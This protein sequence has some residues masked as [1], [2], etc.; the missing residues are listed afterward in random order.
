M[1]VNHTPLT[2]APPILGLRPSAGASVI[3]A[4]LLLA[5]FAQAGLLAE[6]QPVRSIPFEVRDEQKP[7]IAARVA[8][9]SG[10]VMFDNG[11]PDLLFLNRAALDLPERPVIATGSASSGQVISVQAHPAPPVEIGG[12][13]L[14]LPETI[15]SGDFGFTG[16][17]LGDDFLGFIG[18]KMIENDA[19]LLDYARRR[20]L[21]F[22]VGKDGSLPVAAPAGEDVLASVPFL[23]WPGEQPTFAA[24]VGAW[25]VIVDLDTGD[26]GTLYLAA[27]T[28]ERL[29]SQQLLQSEGGRWRLHGMTIGGMA[30]KPTPVRLVEAGGADDLRAAGRADQLRLG[31]HFLAENPCLLNF[32]A[33]T[34]TFLKPDATILE[35]LAG[36]ANEPKPS[37]PDPT[38]AP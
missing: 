8:G 37:A 32:H 24:T 13:P 17:G 19:V 18:V 23:I 3:A 21:V 7:L 35:T 12:Q 4:A 36:S 2:L 25:P 14:S 15:R 38:T 28:R 26:G 31:S 16:P 6:G 11:T 34:L 33:K 1:M 29:R 30:F 22:Q 27:I 10:V 20:L 5:S 9:R